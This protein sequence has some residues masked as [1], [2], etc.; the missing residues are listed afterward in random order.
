VIEDHVVAHECG[1][2]IQVVGVEASS[3]RPIQWRTLNS[4]SGRGSLP[5]AGRH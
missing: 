1:D 3:R 5:V 4:S 2:P